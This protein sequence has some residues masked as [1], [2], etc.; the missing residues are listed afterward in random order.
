MP[1]TTD[2]GKI[3][4]KSGAA[5]GTGRVDLVRRVR[6]QMLES[7]RLDPTVADE[8]IDLTLLEPNHSAEPIGRQLTFVDEP[9]QRPRRQ[10]E[11]RRRLFG[12]EPISIGLRH[13]D[14]VNTLSN[15][16]NTF[17]AT[18]SG[19]KPA[20]ALQSQRYRGFTLRSRARSILERLG[21]C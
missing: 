16:L 6:V 21:G 15:H 7:P 8:R 19:Q 17:A 14:Q 5:G 3:E 13:A 9:V 10:S 2:A 20:P 11:R 1:G 12:R 18:A 4:P